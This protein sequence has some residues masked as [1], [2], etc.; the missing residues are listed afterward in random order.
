[1]TATQLPPFPVA[2]LLTQLPPQQAVH[3]FGQRDDFVGGARLPGGTEAFVANAGASENKP[4]SADPY[5]EVFRTI[6]GLRG[7]GGEPVDAGARADT[8]RV[9]E[10]GRPH[11][12]VPDRVNAVADGSIHLYYFGAEILAGGAH[13]RYALVECAGQEGL[14]VLVADRVDRT[15]GK[16]WCLV[17]PEELDQTLA[18]IRAFL[19]H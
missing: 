8:L 1:M 2:R 19:R 3:H 11:G 7:R 12:I 16:S 10:A 5:A 4:E 14:N 17:G 6:R 18:R 13:R 15:A 9:V